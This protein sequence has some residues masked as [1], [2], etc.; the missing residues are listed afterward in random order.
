MIS[1]LSSSIDHLIIGNEM[2]MSNNCAYIYNCSINFSFH[3]RPYFTYWVTFVQILVF[4]VSV[5]VYGIA[6]IG[7]EETYYDEPVSR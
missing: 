6:P 3:C 5:S 2:K 4:I 1:Y 7:V